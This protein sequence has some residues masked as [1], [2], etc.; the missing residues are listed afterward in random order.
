ML[1]S[2]EARELGGRRSPRRLQEV[3]GRPQ[4]TTRRTPGGVPEAP[5]GSQEASRRPLYPR[6][7][8]EAPGDRQETV[9]KPPRSPQNAPKSPPGGPKRDARSGPEA[10]KRSQE[11]PPRE[12]QRGTRREYNE[13]RDFDDHL[14]EIRGFSLVLV[15]TMAENWPQNGPRRKK[16]ASE[17][18]RET[19]REAKVRSKTRPEPQERDPKEPQKALH[20]PT[21]LWR[22]YFGTSP[23]VLLSK[24]EVE[25][26]IYE[27]RSE[28][29]EVPRV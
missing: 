2:L 6:F 29:Y 14:N 5:G 11:P 28:K 8:Q 10:P 27:V 21:V 12:S 18:P 23:P 25:R 22:G 9:R 3:R 19:P 17:T 16:I 15:A 4:E 20:V 7:R 1:G 24:R 26:T 13:K